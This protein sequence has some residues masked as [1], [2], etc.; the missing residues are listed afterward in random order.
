M[1]WKKLLLIILLISILA[2]VGLWIFKPSLIS[3]RLP[4]GTNLKFSSMGCSNNLNEKIFEKGTWKEFSDG[5]GFFKY[6]WSDEK[7]LEILTFVGMNCADEVSDG[8]AIVSDDE[9]TLVYK[10][11]SPSNLKAQCSCAYILNYTFSEIGKKN[12]EFIIR[13]NKITGL[14]VPEISYVVMQSFCF[15]WVNTNCEGE[16]PI[17]LCNSYKQIKNTDENCSDIK[18]EIA[19][20]CGCITQ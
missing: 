11:S 7:N 6:R 10:K 8:Y 3:S 13:E 12:Y 5:N 16:V 2:T 18:E 14:S 19:H 20:I 4:Q 17:Y 1:D 9:I 15:N